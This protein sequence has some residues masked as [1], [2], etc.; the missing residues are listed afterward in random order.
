MTGL[1]IHVPFC[2]AKCSYCGFYSDPSS[3]DLAVLYFDAVMRDLAARDKKEYNTLYI[4]GGTPS[5]VSPLILAAFLE[6]L[7]DK[8][9]NNFIESTIEAN[10][11]SVT[12][13]FLSVVSDCGFS[14]ISLG[15]QSTDDN[16]LKLL[17]RI[18]DRK[19]IFSAVDKIRAKCSKADLNVDMIYD[20]PTVG[21]PVSMRTLEELALLE[22]QH[23]S[24]YTYSFDTGY[25]KDSADG[26]DTDFSE[27][28]NRLEAKGFHKYEISNFALEGHESR[29]N[30]NYW[31]LGDYDGLGASAWSLSNGQNNRKLSGKTADIQEYIKKP[32]SFVEE[33]VSKG[34][35]LIFEDV[36]FGLRMLDGIDISV[37][38]NKY[39]EQSAAMIEKPLDELIAKGL[40]ACMGSMVRLTERGELLLDSVQEYLWSRLP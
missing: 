38:N 27:V 3:Y 4:G 6:R 18:H 25:L 28:K 36:V 24:A 8:V 40:L 17:G 1:Y 37:L 13:D 11:E 12:D 14:R 7:F 22:P 9:G 26:D 31:R 35:E 16:V 33:N 2:R 29:H 32:E 15:C 39:G 30:I 10:P 21:S 5:S 34:M 19:K 20:I 23:I